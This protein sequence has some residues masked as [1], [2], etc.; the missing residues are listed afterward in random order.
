MLSSLLILKKVSCSFLFCF[1]NALQSSCL[2]VRRNAKTFQF[3]TL[4]LHSTVRS[5][6]RKLL[7][8]IH[9][10]LKKKNSTNDQ[11]FA[12]TKEN[13]GYAAGSARDLFMID[14]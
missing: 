5:S 3:A 10:A 4:A 11:I 13:G 6:F 9:L 12:S 2:K 8:T 14:R 7:S 1:F